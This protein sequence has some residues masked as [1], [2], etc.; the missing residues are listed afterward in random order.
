MASSDDE[1]LKRAIALLL[2][3][4]EPDREL[5]SNI[6][7]AGQSAGNAINLDSDDGEA[8][9]DDD[10]TTD[11]ELKLQMKAE[12]G[13]ANDANGHLPTSKFAN[14]LAFLGTDRKRMEEDRLARRKRKAS[15]PS[16][17]ARKSAKTTANNH[18][19]LLSLDKRN[20]A[21]PT[22]RALADIQG[23][24][25]VEK[26]LDSLYMRGTVKKTW[27]FGYP[28]IGDDIKLE[29]ILLKNDLSLAVLS[30]F[31]WDMDWLLAK[32]DLRSM[33]LQLPARSNEGFNTLNFC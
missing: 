19:E 12:T 18:V 9:T 8:T 1:D 2:H 4:G 5:D 32:I 23:T 20:S 15:T 24:E 16:P 6:S 21:N 25:K 22:S 33:S 29:E 13:N 31:Q 11:G 3:G 26:P 27:A 28:R 14:T 17:P 7:N 10:E 30:S